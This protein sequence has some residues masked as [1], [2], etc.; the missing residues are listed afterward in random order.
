MGDVCVLKI[1]VVWWK[2]MDGDGCDIGD[3]GYRLELE[4]KVYCL[5]LNNNNIIH[6]NSMFI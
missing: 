2:G 1:V 3:M 6:E 5:G 4:V